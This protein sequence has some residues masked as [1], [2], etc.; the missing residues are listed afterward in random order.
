MLAL[1]TIGLDE[2]RVKLVADPNGDAMH[3]EIQFSSSVGSMKLDWYGV[4]SKLNA[5]TSAD[6]PFAVVKALRNLS[7]TVFYGI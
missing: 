1:S 2:T 7:S 3:T 4:P 6:V 5:S